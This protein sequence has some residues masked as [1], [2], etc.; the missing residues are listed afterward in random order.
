VAELDIDQYVD[1]PRG[2]GRVRNL[3]RDHGEATYVLVQ[4]DSERG[5][6]PLWRAFERGA[7]RP[8]TSAGV[9]DSAVTEP[10]DGAPDMATP[11]GALPQAAPSGVAPGEPVRPPK[12]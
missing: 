8:V 10:P 3:V 5:K 9:G 11:S 7:V 12:T 1:T 4:L 2:P 6:E